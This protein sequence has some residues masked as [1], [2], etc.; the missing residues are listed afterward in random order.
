MIK[1]SIQQEE[2]TITKLYATN[3]KALSNVKQ[4]LM[5]LKKYIDSI[6][7]IVGD[8]DFPLN[9]MDRS[10]RQKFSKATIEITQTI[11]YIDLIDN[12]QNLSFYRDRLPFCFYQ[13][14]ENWPGLIPL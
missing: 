11:E 7:I 5:D 10:T 6:K 3:A 2:I 1:W 9:S 13:Y 8:F 4:V 14:I 12:L